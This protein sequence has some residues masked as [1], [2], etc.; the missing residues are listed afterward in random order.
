MG[1]TN[2]SRLPALENGFACCTTGAGGTTAAA[3]FFSLAVGFNSGWTAA[4]GF[5]AKGVVFG[6]ADAVFGLAGA[7]AGFAVVAGAMAAFA[8]FVVVA[9]ATAA[10]AG[11]AGLAGAFAFGF[12]AADAIAGAFAWADLLVDLV[13]NAAVGGFAVDEFGDFA[14]GAPTDFVEGV[15]FGFADDVVDFLAC[16]FDAEEVADFGLAGAFTGSVAVP[17]CAKATLALSSS[18]KTFVRTFIAMPLY[19]F[20]GA[21][22]GAGGAGTAILLE[23]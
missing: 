2:G 12:A 11:I 10:F 18:A 13:T 8:G 23:S 15:A 9:G 7:V 20:A 1:L 21:A 14:A 4:A 17:V 16:A 22:P 5:C 3:G 19:F 6:G